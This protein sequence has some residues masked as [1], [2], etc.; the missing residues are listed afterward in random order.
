MLSKED[1]AL[2][3][4]FLVI[5]KGKPGLKPRF[6]NLTGSKEAIKGYYARLA[7][8]GE[9]I[10]YPTHE[11]IEATFQ[12]ARDAKEEVRILNDCLSGCRRVFDSTTG[13]PI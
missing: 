2:S 5:R 3:G 11:V 6:P 13:F 1:L 4:R 12:T 10:A 8:I 7:W 9:L